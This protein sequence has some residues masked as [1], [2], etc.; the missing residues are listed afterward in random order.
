MFVALFAFTFFLNLPFGA[1]DACYDSLRIIG[2]VI[3][4]A[5]MYDRSSFLSAHPSFTKIVDVG[6][7]QSLL[8]NTV[9]IRR[10]GVTPS[11]AIRL[12]DLLFEDDV[13][14]S[15]HKH[16]R[17][18]GQLALLILLKGFAKVFQI[19]TTKPGPLDTTW[20]AKSLVILALLQ[21]NTSS[22]LFNTSSRLTI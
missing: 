13:L 14:R 4:Q 15:Q 20:V 5:T 6:S 12:A 8:G 2:S 21:P 19:G 18:V 16:G 7:A 9:F 22:K 11:F 10:F 1:P 3:E 17:M